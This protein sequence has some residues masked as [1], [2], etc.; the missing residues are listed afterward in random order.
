M[1]KAAVLN[2]VVTDIQVGHVRV[3][4]D[5]LSHHMEPFTADIV[6]LDVE[7]LQCFII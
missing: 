1:S 3:L 4:C 2:I 5:G 6:V 7:L